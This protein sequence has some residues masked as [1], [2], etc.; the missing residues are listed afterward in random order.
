MIVEKRTY[1]VKYA[2]QDAVVEMIKEGHAVLDH[3]LT[4]RIYLPDLA[5]WGV[6]VHEIEFKDLAERQKFWEAWFASEKGRAFVQRW[7]ELV[8]DGGKGE[9][10]HLAD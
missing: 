7:F 4:F 9:T 6:V 5:P 3:P 10:W 2:N 1:R 8:E